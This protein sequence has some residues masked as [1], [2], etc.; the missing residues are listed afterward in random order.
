M[1]L[2]FVTADVDDDGVG[3]Y[4]FCG[5]QAEHKAIQ[6]KVKHLGIHR[7]EEV[8]VPTSKAELIKWLNEFRFVYRD[9]EGNVIEKEG[10]TSEPAASTSAE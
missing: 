1:K 4:E 5:T 3:F 8:D 9:A 7:A 6:K 2:Y 10:T